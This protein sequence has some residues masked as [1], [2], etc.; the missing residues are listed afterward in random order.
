MQGEFIGIMGSV[1]CGKS[2]L[3]AAIL[4]ELNKQHGTISVFD[5][6]KGFGLV[7]QQPWLQRGTIRENILFG[8][9]YDESKYKN[10]INACCLSDDLLLLPAGDSTGV[11]EG[12]TTLS[13][14]QKARIA[15]ARAVY[16]DK[17]I[18]LLD[19]IISAVDVKVAR[20]IFQHCI[21][22]LLRNKTRL[23]CTHHVHYLIHADRIILMDEGIIKNIGKPA[24]VLQDIDDFIPIDLELGE[25]SQSGNTSLLDSIV[26][27]VATENDSVLNEELRET[28]T[29]SV[30]VYVSYW[31]A[32]GCLLSFTILLSMILMQTSRNMTDWWL[33]YWVTSTGS[34]NATNTSNNHESND[35][36]LWLEA[37]YLQTENSIGYYMLIYGL[38]AGFNS[39]FTLFRAFLFAFGGITAAS[40]VHKT[41]LKT[42]MKVKRNK[43]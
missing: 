10:V 20:H 22:G 33:S 29:V 36:V 39:L 32:V 16:Q 17:S 43:N 6:D 18:Y 14:G 38:L 4:A 15:L 5:L 11:G 26:T 37:N 21:M 27:E 8:K 13:G 42:I 25:N 23:L 34:N 9:A 40:H 28:G 19:D 2:S 7:T 1:G 30:S 3:Y 41:V 35:L 12:G 31:K 24:D